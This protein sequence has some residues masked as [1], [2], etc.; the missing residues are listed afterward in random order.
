MKNL[1]MLNLPTPILK[2]CLKQKKRSGGMKI[3]RTREPKVIK[4]PSTTKEK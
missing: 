2:I 1:L 3:S 4:Q